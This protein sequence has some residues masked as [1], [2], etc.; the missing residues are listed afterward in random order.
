[1]T[2]FYIDYKNLKNVNCL[3]PNIVAS[4]NSTRRNIGVLRWRIP[5]ELLNK[6]NLRNRLDTV[7]KRLQHIEQKVNSIYNFTNNCIMQYKNV[8]Q[9]NLNL[10][11]KFL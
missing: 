1:M 2:E 8:E 9:T 3:L 7:C 10:S 11:D 4:I 6:R 5:E